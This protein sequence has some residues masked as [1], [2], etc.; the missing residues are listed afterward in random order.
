MKNLIVLI[1]VSFLVLIVS[2][3]SDE[4]NIENTKINNTKTVVNDKFSTVNN[5]DNI[6]IAKEVLAKTIMDF[7]EQTEWLSNFKYKS[8]FEQIIEVIKNDDLK[9]YDAF[10]DIL[11]FS[12][13]T[14]YKNDDFIK[15]LKDIDFNNLT[16]LAFHEKWFFNAESMTFKKDVFGVVPVMFIKNE[17]KMLIT[18]L[19]YIAKSNNDSDYKLLAKDIIYPVNLGNDEGLNHIFGLDKEQ[20]IKSV[21]DKLMSS[22]I[23][24]YSFDGGDKEISLEELKIKLGETVDT[25]IVFNPDTQKDVQLIEKT[26]I[27][28][29]ELLSEIVFVEDWYYS[30]KTFMIKKEVKALKL[31]RTYDHPETGLPLKTAICTVMLK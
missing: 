29:T 18:P 24:A 20:F 2:C 7:K 30:P 28:I 5:N 17:T 31:V 4:K 19:F 16:G 15:N 12:T 21:F 26:K 22:E 8:Y 1:S 6:L 13:K 11:N 27:D 9:I 10:T 3:S 23:K 14:E 25:V